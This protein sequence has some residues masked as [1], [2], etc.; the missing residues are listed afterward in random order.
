VLPKLQQLQ[1]GEKSK[2]LRD[3]GVAGTRSTLE[4]RQG[5]KTETI[6]L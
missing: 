2:S 6:Q 4:E 1:R 5:E 3:K